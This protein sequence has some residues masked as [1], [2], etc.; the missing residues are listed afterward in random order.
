MNISRLESPLRLN[1]HQNPWPASAI[2]D[3]IFA[4]AECSQPCVPPRTTL[5]LADRA[6][7]ERIYFLRHEIFAT[8]LGQHSTND[9]HRLTDSLDEFNLY[10]TAT[11]SDELA[12]FIS[13]TPPT[14]NARAKR[15]PAYSIDKYISRDQL[16]FPIDERTFEIRLLSV[17][18]PWR[19][20]AVAAL[21][22]YGALRWVEAHGGSRIVAIGREAILD[23][24]EKAGL[25]RTAISFQSGAVRYELLH[26][27]PAKLRRQAE[28]LQIPARLERDTTWNLPFPFAKPAACFHGGAFFGA[29]GEKFD[30]LERSQEIINA[31]VLD[32]WFPPAPAVIEALEKWGSWIVRS[33]PPPDSA[34]LIATIA[35]ARHLPDDAILPGAGSSDLIFLALRAWFDSSARVLI[36]D[37]TYG[38]Y[39]HVLE[40]VIRCRVDRFTLKRSQGYRIDSTELGRMLQKNY[41]LVVLVNPNS[42]TGQH[43]R[44]NELEALLAKAPS[45]TRFWIDETYVDY[46]APDQSIERYAAE[47]ENVVVCKSMSKVYALSG[48][49]AAYLCANPAQLEFLRSITPPWAVSLP[50]QI[51]AVRAL[52]SPDYYRQRY[53]E[54]AALR[55]Q[56]KTGL[57]AIGVEV[58]P[59]VANFLLFHLPNSSPSANELIQRCAGRGLFLRDA[60]TMGAQLGPHAV[61]IAVKDEQTNERMLTLLR[62]ML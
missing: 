16:P 21:L 56:L 22:M 1:G 13:I 14:R 8:E 30:H 5:A 46:V 42:P 3:A 33:S 18:K 9:A 7:R 55:M 45:T 39:A 34:G 50:A 12:G 10:L 61:R 6:A 59:A 53:A 54:T 36:L 2:E 4:P 44:R 20:S 49:R 29:I 23:F 43:L 24:Y 19:G 48:V 57:E 51:S 11:I 28:A 27:T 25:N 32:A 17:L 40:K 35:A 52:E 31:D 38:E 41:D 58:I 60:S 26:A 62:Q 47:T 37:P 15:N